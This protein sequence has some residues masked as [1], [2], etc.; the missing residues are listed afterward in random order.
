[1]SFDALCDALTGP[2]N[3]QQHLPPGLLLR[4]LS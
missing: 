4:Y 1:M 3:Q 2:S